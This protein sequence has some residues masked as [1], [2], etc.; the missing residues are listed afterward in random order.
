MENQIENVKPENISPYQEIIIEWNQ[1]LPIETIDDL[2]EKTEQYGERKVLYQIYGDHHIYGRDV[3]VYIG[4]SKDL[5]ARFDKHL[6]GVFH[7]LNN[8][9]VSIGLIQDEVKLEVPESILIGNHKPA[10]NK[11]YIHSLDPEAMKH[12]IIVINN[13]NNAMLKTCSTNFWWVN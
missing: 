3:L 6:K 8:K 11:E 1:K 10:F 7:Y 9:S 12:K 2:K 4:I 5:H 13:G